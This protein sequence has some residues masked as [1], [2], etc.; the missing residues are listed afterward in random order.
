MLAQTLQSW[1][2]IREQV[3]LPG[4]KFQAEVPEPYATEAQGAGR[5]VGESIESN[6]LP[7]ARDFLEIARA[8][9]LIRVLDRGLDRTKILV[10]E[11]DMKLFRSLAKYIN[12]D[13]VPLTHQ[14]TK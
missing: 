14:E 10:I 5:A 8:I 6:G 11:D 7:Y 13:F 4:K 9:A 3:N 2:G 1:M 12:L